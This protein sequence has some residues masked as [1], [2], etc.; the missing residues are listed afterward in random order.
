MEWPFVSWFQAVAVVGVG[1]AVVGVAGWLEDSFFSLF[2]RLVMAT[3]VIENPHPEKVLQHAVLSDPSAY[4]VGDDKHAVT[5]G[6]LTV[7]VDEGKI[8][9]TSHRLN[10]NELKQLFSDFIPQNEESQTI[11]NHD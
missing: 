4:Y 10:E 11:E 5:G 3:I 2:L 8:V 6:R 9:I 1:V 7:K